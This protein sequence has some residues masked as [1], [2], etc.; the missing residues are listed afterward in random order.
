VR[1]RSGDVL[2]SDVLFA[3]AKKQIAWFDLIECASM[4][5]AVKVVSWHPTARIGASELRQIWDNL[6][7][8]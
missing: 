5:E 2:V 1:I 7:Q 3:E 8:R 4:A 6:G